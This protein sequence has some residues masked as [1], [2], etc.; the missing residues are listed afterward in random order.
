MLDFGLAK[1]AAEFRGNTATNATP[2]M[3]SPGSTLGT[4]AYMSPEQVRADEVDARTDLFSFGA[5]MY[6]MATGVVAFP[7]S[8]S[9]VVF[10]AILNRMPRP[11]SSVNPSIPARLEEV[12][13]K[14]LEKDRDL[15]YQTAAELRGDLKRIKR[16]LETS[17]ASG[18][19]TSGL[20]TA[21]SSTARGRGSSR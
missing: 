11:V 17:R 7:G 21:W 6:E 1:V 3:T 16:D 10:E 20:P 14:S 12:I 8:S 5:V 4:V 15:R 13:L 18:A 19:S 9:G 2:Q